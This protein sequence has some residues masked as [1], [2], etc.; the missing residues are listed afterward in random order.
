MAV[1]NFN[2]PKFKYTIASTGQPGA[3]YKLFTYEEGTSTKKT[4]WTSLAK[5]GENTNPIIL[6]ANGEADVWI[7]GNYKFVL[8][9]STDTDPP[10]SPVWTYD[11]VRSPLD[12]TTSVGTSIGDKPINGSFEDD[13]DADGIPDNWAVVEY[14][15][16]SVA[17]DTTTSTYG[18]SSLK[19][20]SVGAGGGVISTSDYYEV[21][22]GKTI[23]I[24]FSIISADADTL[25]KVQVNWYNASKVYLSTS[26]A[27]NDGATNPTTWTRKYTS[28]TAPA[29]AKFAKILVTGVDPTSTTHSSTNFD[30]IELDTH[31]LGEVTAVPR[32][33]NYLDL[34]TGPGTQE[35]EKAV[36][37]DSNVNTGVSKVT[38]LHIGASGSEVQVTATPTELNYSSG[39]TS[40]IQT[41]LDTLTAADRWFLLEDWTAT[42]SASKTFTFD[43]TTY[44][45]VRLELEGIVPVND[46]ANLYVRVGHTN[47]GTIV[48]S[49]SY[50]YT[51]TVAG[52]GTLVTGVGA[53]QI[54]ITDGGVGNNTTEGVGGT[55][56]A[57]GFTSDRSPAGIRSDVTY[58]TGA[59]VYKAATTVGVLNTASTTIYDSIQVLFAAGNISANGSIKMYGLKAS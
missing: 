36:V 20:T 49:T 51:I 24:R 59:P 44:I 48:S 35:A 57:V 10:T 5:T 45:A 41:Q 25:N 17:L 31:F 6:D 34:T 43:E 37:A 9:P 52:S 56:E 30:N 32:E 33:I 54:V 19:F 12:P 29:T 50:D 11:A 1:V 40:A 47:G 55:I 46:G 15:G 4:T 3:G 58:G 21:E 16:G 38:E 42:S 18:E 13:T 14:T 53:T 8:A 26:D 2:Y 28:V 39:V 22:A 23:G 7:D 27:Y